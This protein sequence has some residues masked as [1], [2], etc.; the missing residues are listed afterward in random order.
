MASLEGWGFT[1]K[2]YPLLLRKTTRPTPERQGF[3]REIQSPPEGPIPRQIKGNLFFYA[4]IEK[5]SVYFSSKV[6]TRV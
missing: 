6:L 3:F 1:I 4:S 5:E 2:L